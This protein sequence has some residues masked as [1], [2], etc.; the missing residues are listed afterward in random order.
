MHPSPSA[1]PTNG[2]SMDDKNSKGIASHII[3]FVM[4]KYPLQDSW[5]EKQEKVHVTW[6][7]D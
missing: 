6:T 5:Q 2:Q 4:E 1:P 7:A 3:E